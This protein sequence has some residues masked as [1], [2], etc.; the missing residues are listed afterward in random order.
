MPRGGKRPGAGRKAGT[1][2]GREKT[3]QITIRCTPAEKTKLKELAM[4]EGVTLSR[5]ILRRSL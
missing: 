5:Y 1:V 4:R 2:I 3:D